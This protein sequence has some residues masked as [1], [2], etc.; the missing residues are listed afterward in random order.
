[1]QGIGSPLDE[2]RD[3]LDTRRA[4]FV[5]HAEGLP[6]EKLP[7]WAR[8]RA[9]LRPEGL[10]A[11]IEGSLRDSV[12]VGRS[13]RPRDEPRLREFPHVDSE[14]V[15]GLIRVGRKDLE[16]SSAPEGNERVSS[17]DAG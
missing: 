17:A 6:P 1:M 13:G 10:A 11:G 2:E 8:A 9:L 4:E 15:V 12:D 3:R 14:L 16:I 5:H 7:V